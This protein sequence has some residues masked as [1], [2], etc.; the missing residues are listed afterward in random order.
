MRHLPN[1]K[2]QKQNTIITAC[3]DYYGLG[4]NAEEIKSAK[5][6]ALWIMGRKKGIALTEQE[7]SDL[8][9]IKTNLSDET[10]TK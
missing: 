5:K 1:N 4:K 10:Y 2:T 6:I 8:W 9:A 3:F 7:E